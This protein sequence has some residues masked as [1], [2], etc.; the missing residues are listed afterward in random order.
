MKKEII[1]ITAFIIIF[2]IV[3]VF[4]C[5]DNDLDGFNST[6]GGTCGTWKDCNDSNP[7]VNP[8][9]TEI[10]NGIDDDC[11][12]FIDEGGVCGNQSNFT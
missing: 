1:L 3:I 11:D 12:I 8:G 4:A 2:Q 10:C 7:D 9:A 6:I 5:T